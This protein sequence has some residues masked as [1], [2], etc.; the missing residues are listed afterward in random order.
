METETR[1]VI[2]DLASLLATA[3][4]RLKTCVVSESSDSTAAGLEVPAP[5]PLSVTS[6]RVNG[7]ETPSYLGSDA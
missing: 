7:A 3:L 4:L 2:K 1:P 5:A 6:P